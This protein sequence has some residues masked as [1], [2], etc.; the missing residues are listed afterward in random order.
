MDKN[1]ELLLLYQYQEARRRLVAYEDE[2]SEPGRQKVIDALKGRVQGFQAGVEQ[3]H[4]ECIQLRTANRRLED[5]CQD[6]EAQLRQLETNLYSGNISAPKELEQLQRRIAE[7]QKAK[8]EREEAVLSQLYLLE[9]KE[10]ELELAKKN[11]GELREQLTVAIDEEAKRIA[12]LQKHCARL[13]KEVGELEAVLPK[14]YKE[15]YER[16]TKALRGI[17]IIPIK[18]D[19]CGYCHMIISTAVLA[20]IKKG[21]SGIVVCENCGR[22]LFEQR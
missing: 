17:T 2:L 13:T 20:K 1:Q 9:A 3:I 15:Y 11:E 12:T 18:D 6:Y 10:K 8:A 22:G 5:E 4:K 14:E 7:Y 19:T 21:S 16:S